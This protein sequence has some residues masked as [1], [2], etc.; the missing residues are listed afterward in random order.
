MAMYPNDG[1]GME[2]AVANAIHEH[3]KL[4]LI[5]G[6]ILVILGSSLVSLPFDAWEQFSLEAKFGFNR[7]RFFP[8]QE[9]IEA[10]KPRPP[11]P[12]LSHEAG[13]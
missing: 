1:A 2:R 13:M 11:R 3:W 8:N 12:L 4:F 5:E 9:R 6:I 7:S 10:P